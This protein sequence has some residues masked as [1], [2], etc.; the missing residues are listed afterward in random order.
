MSKTSFIQYAIQKINKKCTI[1]SK[2]LLTI[3]ML[4][5][6][7]PI[8]KPEIAD[9]NL[10]EKIIGIYGSIISVLM[11]VII[12]ALLAVYLD[13]SIENNNDEFLYKMYVFMVISPI[14]SISI[15]VLFGILTPFQIAICFP[16]IFG[17]VIGLLELTSKIKIDTSKIEKI[18]IKKGN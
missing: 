9:S 10:T 7:I 15:F 4:S 18:F 5:S 17:I 14:I 16:T 12:F 11:I 1:F 13:F 6:F 3:I 8:P 2:I